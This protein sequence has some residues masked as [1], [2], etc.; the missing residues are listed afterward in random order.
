MTF[1]NADILLH[2]FSLYL[3]KHW[4]IK[5]KIGHVMYLW[6]S[7]FYDSNNNNSKELFYYHIA[8]RERTGQHSDF[9]L[10]PMGLK[11]PKSK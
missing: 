1:P 5:L 6:A 9:T 4:L 8:T 7:Y 3:L 2:D 10:E 11:H